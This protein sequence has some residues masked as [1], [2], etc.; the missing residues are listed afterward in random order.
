[1]PGGK[2]QERERASRTLSLFCIYDNPDRDPRARS[3][4]WVSCYVLLFF[5][6]LTT[7]PT[8]PPGA[9]LGVQGSPCPSESPI[10]FR[11]SLS[12]MGLLFRETS[13]KNAQLYW[14][15]III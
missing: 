3:R 5:S 7:K 6:I 9:V 13:P 8:K 10:K 12:G 1:L 4:A 11:V 15:M 2:S 14:E